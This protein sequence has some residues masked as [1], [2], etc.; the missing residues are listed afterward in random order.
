MKIDSRA[1]IAEG[2]KIGTNVEI[3]P[4]AVIDAD[5]TIGDGCKIGPHA[6]ITGITTLGEG[7][8]VHAGAVI[9]DAPQDVHYNDEP[10]YVD[11]GKNCVIREYVTVHRGTEEGS[12]TVVGNNVMLMAF[13][14]LGHN[15]VIEDGVIVANASLLAGRV[16]VG[17]KAF[18]SAGV[19]VHQFVR[20]GRLAMIGGG[21]HITQD[22]PP[23]CMLQGEEIQG[24]NIVG[25]RRSGMEEE[26]RTALRS[27][28]KTY[29]CYG[30]PR[31]EACDR[32]R[33]AVTI[34]P[35]VQEFIDF[36]MSTKR[37]V[38]PGHKLGENL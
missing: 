35:E 29:F 28:I 37:G 16:T 22:V 20:I 10:S 11:I 13:S 25:L 34:T 19:M 38:C 33:A 30:L 31:Q 2:A 15:C 7:T 3:G 1:V 9:G 4:Y 6:Y 36:V 12:H 17:A 26:A 27:A 23:F 24:P 18:V 14:H 8:Q 21:N 32:I 5:V